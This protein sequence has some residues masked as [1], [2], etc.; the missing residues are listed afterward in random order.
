MP[1]YP[2]TLSALLDQPD[3]TPASCPAFTQ[4]FRH[5]SR[6]MLAAV[7]YL[8]DQMNVAHR[9]VNPKNFV[10]GRQG[11]VKLIDFGIAIWADQRPKTPRALLFLTRSVVCFTVSHPMPWT[12]AEGA[13]D[14][15]TG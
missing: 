5:F 8:H 9:D 15:G 1:Y 11:H 7:A 3:F 4:L 14:V 10:I 6:Q 2:I 13:F 12:V